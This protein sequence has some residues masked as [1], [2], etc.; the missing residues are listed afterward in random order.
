MDMWA[1]YINS[2]YAHTEAAIV[3]DKFH[4]ANTWVMPWI[5][6]DVE[7]IGSCAAQ[8]TSAWSIARTYG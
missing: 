5:R 7:R 4:I 6:S 8:A 1:P 3:F 2:V